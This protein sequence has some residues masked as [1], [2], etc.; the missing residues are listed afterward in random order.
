MIIL[1][2]FQ[3][4]KKLKKHICIIPRLAVYFAAGTL[5]GVSY[6]QDSNEISGRWWLAHDCKF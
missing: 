2:Y 4:K 3:N 5:N 1:I 6:I